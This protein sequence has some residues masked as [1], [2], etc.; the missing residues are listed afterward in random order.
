MIARLP[1][2]VPLLALAGFLVL[3][4][5]TVAG[6]TPLDRFDSAVSDAFRGHGDASPRLVDVLRVATDVAATVPFLAAGL[7]VTV[8]LAIR[9]HRPAAT[10]CAVVTVLVPVLWGLMH[11]LVHHPRPED[12]FVVIDSNGFPSGHTSNA[13]AAALVAVLLLW[14]RLGRPARVLTVALAVAFGVFVGL[15]RV[16]LLA[17][18][19]TDVL[20]GWLLALA[21]VPLAAR[22]VERPATSPRPSDHHPDHAVR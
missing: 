20:G 12:G 14:S 21:V 7:A 15:T 1:L 18:W 6:W 13:A 8:G 9:R 5:L 16:A 3:L 19:P 2:A 17:H 11:W 22:M 4:A 10:L